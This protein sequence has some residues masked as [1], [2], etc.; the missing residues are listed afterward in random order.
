MIICAIKETKKAQRSRMRMG[1]L[2]LGGLVRAGVCGN[3][4]FK[5]ET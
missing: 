5:T 1:E 4:L 2:P 3:K